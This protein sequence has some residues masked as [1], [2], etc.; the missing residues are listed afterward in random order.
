MHAG[1]LNGSV[2]VL[3]KD[4]YISM[5]RQYYYNKCVF[6]F[7]AFNNLLLAPGLSRITISVCLI[8]A[9]PTCPR[10]YSVKVFNS[11]GLSSHKV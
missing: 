9:E 11:V 2:N 8:T 6:E 5:Q 1:I 3:R 4:R 10:K 7:H